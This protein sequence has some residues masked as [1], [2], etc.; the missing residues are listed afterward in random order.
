MSD[1]SPPGPPSSP[2]PPNPEDRFR[3]GHDMSE[4]PQDD[5]TAQPGIRV[6]GIRGADHP[7]TAYVPD[8]QLWGMG[9]MWMGLVFGLFCT[10]VAATLLV[11]LTDYS[12]GLD[13]LPMWLFALVTVS[14]HAGLLAA[15]VASGTKGFGW[16]RDWRVSMK[17]RDIPIG[18]GFGLASQIVIGIL[19][20]P[21]LDLLNKDIEEVGE[22]ARELSARASDV[23]GDIS[24]IIMVGL[25][26]PIVEELFFRGVVY[27]A[28]DKSWRNRPKGRLLAILASSLI[29][30][31][32][33][34]QGLQLPALFIIGAV[35]AL[36]VHRYDRLGPAIWAH[37]GFNMTTVISLLY[38]QDL[39]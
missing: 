10:I 7:Q 8:K 2:P 24:L 4:T 29:F 20:L 28:M 39:P 25:V 21:F 27:R 38:L 14:L 19:Y 12:A 18:L 15:T 33:H 6:L 17:P 5:V 9:D 31:G 1:V 22:P 26:A 16:L 13:D 36:L 3:H 23:V 37:I 34:F 35:L 32:Y 11:S 30:A